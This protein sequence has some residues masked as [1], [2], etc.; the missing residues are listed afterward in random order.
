MSPL[1]GLPSLVPHFPPFYPYLLFPCSRFPV[2]FSL[3]SHV[4]GKE[5]EVESILK[6]R[7][8]FAVLV[9]GFLYEKR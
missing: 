4:K 2:I 3:V 7:E 6:Y 1:Q 8:S 9:F 5:I